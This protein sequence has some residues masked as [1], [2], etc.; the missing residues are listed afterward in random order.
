MLVKANNDTQSSLSSAQLQQLQQVIHQ[1]SPLQLA[2][3][4]GYLAAKSETAPVINPVQN[5]AVAQPI[6]TILFGS[7]TG[8]AKTIAEQV[9]ADAISQGFQANVINMADYKPKRLKNETH[10]LI[11]AST[12]GEGEP[13]DDAI[14]LHDF[15]SSKRAPKLESLQYSVLA[16]GDSSYEFFC[17]TGKDFDQKLAAL[18]AKPFNN[19]VDCDVDYQAQAKA[20]QEQTLKDLEADL[21]NQ[22]AEVVTLPLD[23]IQVQSS[24]SIYNKSNPFVATVIANQ[25]ITG[26][27]SNKVVQHLEIDLQGSELRYLPGDALGII[28]NNDPA[29]VDK[30]LSLLQLS[31][32]EQITINNENFNLKDALVDQLE[33]TSITKQVI[34][35]WLALNNNDAL[36]SLVADNA[37]L[38]HYINSHQFVD[39]IKD[40]PAKVTGQQLVDCLS[41]IAPRLYSIASSQEEVEDEVH[42]TVALVDYAV[43]ESDNNERRLGCA[44]GYLIERLDVD[45]QVKVFIEHN[46][47]FRLP[48]NQNTD[49][50]MVGPGTGI[51]PFRAF[52]QH[53]ESTES[54]GKN[55]LFFG[56]QTFTQDFLYQV[57]LQNYLKSGVLSGLDVA[58]SRDQIE[59]VYVQHKLQAKGAEVFAWLEEGAHFYIC[60]DMARMA[61]DVENTLLDIIAKHG[62]KNPEQA[63]DYL[64]QLR[65]NKRYQKDVY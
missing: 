53:R 21:K 13:P 23:S 61:K 62:D 27:D 17:Q 52:L 9:Y 25:K 34:N 40:Y 26:R 36:T 6:L 48:D 15:L 49:V 30:V 50:I 8:N 20:W 41:R 4:S 2:W 45:D 54:D 60:G 1:Y 29:L 19:R 51:A 63:T 10:L 24:S 18:G 16:L 55:W 39:F 35:H 14:L 37:A 57:E 3:A 28:P 56:D 42:L 12:N 44:S 46:N 47:N 38:R 31:S 5:S 33:I 32:A 65:I 7:Q 43:G 58:F 64:K 22:K 59:K 11:V